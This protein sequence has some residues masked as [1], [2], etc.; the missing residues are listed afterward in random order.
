LLEKLAGAYLTNAGVMHVSSEKER[1]RLRNVRECES[2]LGELLRIALKRP[3]VRRPT[4]P[5]RAARERRLDKKKQRSQVKAQRRK[6][7][8]D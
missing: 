4:K 6:N 5:S 2:K 8:D 3:K 1:S 7:H